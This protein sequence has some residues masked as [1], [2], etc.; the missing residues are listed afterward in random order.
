MAARVQA[1]AAPDVCQQ[2]IQE[3]C[4]VAYHLDLQT[5]PA[6]VLPLHF[7]CSSYAP[8]RHRGWL[9]AMKGQPL[10]SRRVKAQPLKRLQLLACP[11]SFLPRQLQSPLRASEL[12]TSR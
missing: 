8:G 3:H 6:Q 1:H 5:M 2:L 11:V 7:R 10:H 9:Q 4:W 12:L